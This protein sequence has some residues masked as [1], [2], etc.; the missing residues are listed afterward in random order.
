M[1]DVNVHHDAEHWTCR[2]WYDFHLLDCNDL[3]FQACLLDASHVWHV[4]M[5]WGGGG[6][7]CDFPLVLLSTCCLRW[8]P[9]QC[10]TICR[11]SRELLQALCILNWNH[12]WKYVLLYTLNMLSWLL[13]YGKFQSAILILYF[14]KFGTPTKEK[15][16]IHSWFSYVNKVCLKLDENC[17][18]SSLLEILTSEILQSAPN[19]PPN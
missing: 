16:C 4:W 5:G 6:V 2:I 9:L 11:L 13:C 15:A 10:Y 1:S 3:I 7:L 12:L 8:Y 18:S 17:G 19:D 14:L